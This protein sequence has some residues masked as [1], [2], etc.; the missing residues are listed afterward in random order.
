VV[1]EGRRAD[2]EAASEHVIQD[3]SG[4]RQAAS[5]K[6]QATGATIRTQLNDIRFYVKE[7]SKKDNRRPVRTI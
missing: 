5:G 4:K 7:R 3:A 1:P 6:L 2:H